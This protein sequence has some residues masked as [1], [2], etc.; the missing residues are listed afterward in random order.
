MTSVD[1][2]KFSNITA[3]ME[4]REYGGSGNFWISFE[5]L[6]NKIDDG[7]IKDLNQ[8]GSSS[9]ALVLCEDVTVPEAL[10]TSTSIEVNPF[11]K[12]TVPTYYGM[13]E[14]G[15]AITFIDDDNRST[16]KALRKWHAKMPIIESGAAIGA[17][18][19]KNYC[20]KIMVRKYDK[21]GD[22]QETIEMDVWPDTV[23]SENLSYSDSGLIK[24]SQTFAL[25]SQPKIS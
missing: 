11:V 17:L 25:I 13:P 4:D 10:L 8:V 3:Q 9:N 23:P 19:I 1:Y 16:K 7:I 15:L 20:L 5:S 18:D 24:V 2:M 21:R 12:L 22:V 6:G 14:E